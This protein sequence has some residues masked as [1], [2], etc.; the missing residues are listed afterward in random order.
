M[1]LNQHNILFLLFLSFIFVLI[2]SCSDDSAKTSST[3]SKQVQE[4]TPQAYLQ[5]IGNL[6]YNR[7]DLT[8]RD[9]LPK[10]CPPEKC[11]NGLI[12]QYYVEYMMDEKFYMVQIANFEDQTTAQQALVQSLKGENRKVDY[13]N[14]KLYRPFYGRYVWN[15]GNYVI[16]VQGNHEKPE[17][18]QLTKQYLTLYPSEV[19]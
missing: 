5:D 10:D 8:A 1:K 7:A 12:T 9:S 19:Q 2:I 16:F 11:P 15:S 4:V 14:T 17:F 3:I 18:D 13:E 6:K